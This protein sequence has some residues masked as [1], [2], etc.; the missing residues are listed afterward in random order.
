MIE[1][2]EVCDMKKLLI[3][4]VIFLLAFGIVSA[5]NE[6]EIPDEN[7]TVDDDGNDTVDDDVDAFQSALGAEIRLLQLESAITRNILWGEEIIAAILDRNSSADVG[8]LEAVLAEL[9]VLGDEVAS[10]TPASGSESAQLFVDLKK[11]AID[12]THEFKTLARSMLKP[13]EADGLRQRLQSIRW[14]ETK[15]RNARIHTLQGEYNAQKVNESFSAIGA[16]NPQLV[17]RVRAGNASLSEVKTSLKEA[18]QNMGADKKLQAVVAL[19]EMAARG[20]VFKRA[21]SEKVEYKKQE[22][23]QTRAENRIE[24]VQGLNLSERVQVRLE[25]RLQKTAEK[26]EHTENQTEEKALKAE[27]VSEK[28]ISHAEDKNANAS[29]EDK[30][31][32]GSEKGKSAGG[33][34]SGSG[35]G[36]GGR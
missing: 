25:S 17:N 11:D 18:V 8:E 26:M 6:T 12:L 7:D 21:V 22:R 14:N 4:S 19:Q 16:G 9:Q 28:K 30:S 24:A 20:N 29:N 23:L 15:E 2:L 10:T 31:Q 32:N 13:N 5:D 3:F 33:N 1:H 36:G 34:G 35:S 27:Q